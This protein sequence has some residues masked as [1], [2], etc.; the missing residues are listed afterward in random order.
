MNNK[1]ILSICV[2]LFLGAFSLNA[3]TAPTPETAAASVTFSPSLVSQY[4]FRGVRL[5]GPSFQPNLE[6]DNGNVAVG[7]WANYPL[8]AK[9]DG[10]SDPEMDVYG[11]YTFTVNESLSIVPG[12]TWYNYPNADHSLGF[13]ES[14]LEPS[15]AL[16]YTING[17]KFTP[18]IYYDVVMDGPTYEL[19]AA[20][21]LALKQIGTELDFTGTIGTYTWKNAVYNANPNIENSGDYWLV[22]VSAPF[23][24]NSSSKVVVGFAY[25][26]G[27]NNFYK[28]G[29]SKMENDAAVGRGV[30]T[31]SYNI[32]F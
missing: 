22:G 6:Y 28:Q 9:V 1:N 8:S 7:A 29:S 26:Q 25:T 13:Y 2:A 18:K 14:T 21:S 31:V 27:R 3:Q 32:T 4:M 11:S 15:L 30:V 17:I 20:W 24:I 16:N 10:V 12:F 19:S 23:T 5:G